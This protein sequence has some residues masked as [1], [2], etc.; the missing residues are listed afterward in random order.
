[1]AMNEHPQIL[2]QDEVNRLVEYVVK[3]AGLDGVPE[4][5]I[6]AIYNWAIE[7]RLNE[8]LLSQVLNGKLAVSV[9]DG[10]ICFALPKGERNG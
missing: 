10:E 5:D 4:P 1:M 2:S 7:A 3:F 8:T 6:D 9:I